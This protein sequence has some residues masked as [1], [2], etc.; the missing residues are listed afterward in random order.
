LA[1]CK[2]PGNTR[3]SV[4]KSS[5]CVCVWFFITSPV[6]SLPAYPSTFPRSPCYNSGVYQF[7][8]RA[9][10]SPVDVRPSCAISHRVTCFHPANVFKFVF[11]K[12]L[13]RR[14]KHKLWPV[15][16]L[17]VGGLRFF[18]SWYIC[19]KQPC[20]IASHSVK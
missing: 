14:W 4:T 10:L 20:E 9:L 6:R 18:L 17:C 16:K 7:A 2:L 5:R 12:I 1:F 11:A 15:I 3:P 8:G 13:L 19:H